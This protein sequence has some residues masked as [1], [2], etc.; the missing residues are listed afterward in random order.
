MLWIHS[1]GVARAVAKRILGRGHGRKGRGRANRSMASQRRAGDAGVV[2]AGDPGVVGYRSA[3]G[4]RLCDAVVRSQP[5]QIGAL[6][7]VGRIEGRPCGRVRVVVRCV[8]RT[9]Q[10][11][12]ATAVGYGQEI[13]LLHRVQRILVVKDVRIVRRWRRGRLVAAL[14]AI[15]AASH[16]AGRWE[17]RPRGPTPFLLR[18]QRRRGALG[19]SIVCGRA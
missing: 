15:G 4:W 1:I 7:R 6:G 14:V 9:S 10:A 5:P 18:A 19:V 17:S 3:G 13:I 11:S 2:G 16:G 12:R 8:E